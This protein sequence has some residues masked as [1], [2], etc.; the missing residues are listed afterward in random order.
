MKFAK[1]TSM[2]LA[3]NLVDATAVTVYATATA[4]SSAS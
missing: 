1:I 3:I 4:S 2:I